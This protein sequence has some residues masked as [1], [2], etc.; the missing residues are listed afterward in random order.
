M[1]ISIDMFISLKSA[2]I[3]SFNGIFLFVLGLYN[4]CAFLEVL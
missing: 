4:D 1:R 2:I 3:G